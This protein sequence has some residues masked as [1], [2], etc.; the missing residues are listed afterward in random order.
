MG[1]FE[2]IGSRFWEIKK[3]KSISIKSQIPTSYIGIWDF[4]LI[5]FRNSYSF[6]NLLLLA[7]LSETTL[8]K[9]VPD[10]KLETSIVFV[11]LA[12]GIT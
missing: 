4:Y 2:T 9:Y 11:F 10:F 7:P 12:F 8:M 5:E 6:T 3:E 1:N